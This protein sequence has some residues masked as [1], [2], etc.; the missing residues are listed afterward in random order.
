MCDVVGL[1]LYEFE[2]VVDCEYFVVEVVEFFGVGSIELV[3]IDDEDGSVVLEDF[4]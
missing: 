2:V 1:F 3:E 4:N